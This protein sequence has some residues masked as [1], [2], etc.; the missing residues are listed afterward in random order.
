MDYL[1]NKFSALGDVFEF[2]STKEKFVIAINSDLC[3]EILTEMNYNYDE[4]AIFQ[5]KDCHTVTIIEAPLIIS[6]Q[7]AKEHTFKQAQALAKD[8]FG[9][10]SNNT[11]LDIPSIKASKN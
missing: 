2:T 3:K 9:Y 7:F 4:A 8:V 11:L 6:F 5:H 1:F 10:Y